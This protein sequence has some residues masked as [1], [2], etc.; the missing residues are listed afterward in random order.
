ML[1]TSQLFG[2]LGAPSCSSLNRAHSIPGKPATPAASDMVSSATKHRASFTNLCSID[3]SC[4][5]VNAFSPRHIVSPTQSIAPPSSCALF[6]LCNWIHLGITLVCS[7][8]SYSLFCCTISSPSA[9]IATMYVCEPVAGPCAVSRHDPRLFLSVA[10]NRDWLKPRSILSARGTCAVGIKY[11]FC[12]GLLES[13]TD[14]SVVALGNT[15]NVECRY[16]T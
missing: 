3:F 4:V 5:T 11:T 2:Q 7:D 14:N 15:M 10:M 6:S 9:D 1:A 8:D 13:R 12:V 16:N